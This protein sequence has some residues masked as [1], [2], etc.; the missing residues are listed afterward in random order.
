MKINVLKR[1]IPLVVIF[2]CAN[3]T[4]A[5]DKNA[6]NAY[7]VALTAQA[8]PESTGEG[9]VQL[10]LMDIKGE[11]MTTTP[12]AELN[13]SNPSKASSVT[14]FGLTVSAVSGIEID[15]LQLSEIGDQ[16]YVTSYAYYKAESEAA[17]G[18]YFAGWKINSSYVDKK[19]FEGKEGSFFKVLPGTGDNVLPLESMKDADAVQ[20]AKDAAKADT[21]YLYAVWKKY[22]LS[23]PIATNGQVEGQVGETEKIAVSFDLEGDVLAS[24]NRNLS[25]IDFDNI[26]IEESGNEGGTWELLEDGISI[27]EENYTPQKLT[28]TLLAGFTVNQNTTLGIHKATLTIQTAG[29][30][31]SELKIPIAVTVLDPNRPEA[32][33]YEEKDKSKNEIGDWNTLYSHIDNYTNPVLQLNTRHNSDLTLDKDFT[34]DLNGNNVGN[35][36]I[37]S[38]N[39]TIAYSKFGGTA[40]AVMVNGGKLI[41]N[42]G[43]FTS[44][45]IAQGATVEQNGATITSVDN[46]GALTT[47]EGQIQGGLTSSGTLTINGGSFAGDNAITITGG[48][49]LLKRGSINGTTCGVL[50]RG[51]TTTIEK[52]A[53]INGGDNYNSVKNEGGVVNVNCGKFGNPLVGNINF[54]SGYFKTDN[55][56]VSTIGMT[57]LKLTAGVE[58]NEGYQYFLGTQDAAKK[59]GVAVCRIGETG[60]ATLEDALAYANNNKDKEVIIFMTRDYTLPA[61]YYT[62][63]KEAT[64]VVP[65]DDNQEKLVNEVAPKIAFN[66]YQEE[67]DK[68]KNHY[69]QNT[70]WEFR[71]LTFAQGV[72]I[73]VFGAIEMTCKQ[74]SS[75]EA[76]TGQPVGPYGHL[77][78][79][80]GSHMT[81]QSGS[82]LRA[83]GFMTG[84]GE[85]DAR[86]GATVHEFFQMG[87]WKGALTSARIVGMADNKIESESW[88]KI[89]PVS[90]YFI[91]NIESPVTY[92]PGAVLTTA[93]AVSDG[94]YGALSVSMTANDIK[95]IGVSGRDNAI[96]LMDNTADAENTWVKKSY[97]AEQDIQNYDV[98]SCAHIGSMEINLGTI[99][100]PL[101][102]LGNVPILLNSAKFD[103]PITSNMKLHLRSGSMDFTQNTS[104][105]PGSEV[106]VDKESIV[107]IFMSEDDQAAKKDGKVYYS[108]ALYVYDADDWGE[109]AFT[110]ENG[111]KGTAFTKIVRYTPSWDYGVYKGRPNLRKENERPRSAT[112]NVHGT[113]DTDA[114]YVYTSEH[115]ANI[116]SSN[117]DAGTFIFHNS[118]ADAGNPE[119]YNIIGEDDFEPL[120]FSPAKLKNHDGSYTQ[121]YIDEKHFAKAGEAY[122]Y[123]DS[124]WSIW[125]VA[126]EDGNASCFMT[127]GTD[128]YAKPQEYVK[129]VATKN[130][131]G[132]LVGNTDHTYSDAAG[133]GR[134]F[135]IEGDDCQWWE[136]EVKDNLYHCIHPDN[137]TYYEWNDESGESGE[138]REKR[139]T[140]TWQ[141]WDGTIIKTNGGTGGEET[142]SYS[143]PYG[144]MAEFLGSNP[145]RLANIDYTYDFTG[146]T[147]ALGKVTSDV[148]YTA[149][150]E[151][152]SRKYTITFCNEGGSVIERQFLTHNDVPVCENTPTKVGHYL[153]WD[154]AIAAVTG[155]ATYTATWL[156][157][158][159]TKYEVRFVDYDGTEL[160][161][162]MMVTA[163][164]KPEYT[165]V[166]PT[167]KA[168]QAEK[169]G[170]KEFTY[171][172]DHWSPKITPVDAAITYTAVYKE[173]AKTYTVTFLNEDGSEIEHHNYAYGKVPVCSNIP[174]KANDAQYTYTLGWKPQIEAVR[175]D[176]TGVDAYKATWSKTTNKYTIT[177]TS[178]MP[179]AVVLTGAGIYD[180]NTQVTLQ[181]KAKE[182]EGFVFKGWKE[183]NNTKDISLTVKADATY[184]AIVERETPVEDHTV[185]ADETWDAA[186]QTVK[187]LILCSNGIQSGQIKNIT[188]LTLDGNAYFDLTLNA[189]ADRWY[190]IAVPWTVNVS[191]IRF[192]GKSRTADRDYYLTYYQGN[193]RAAQGKVDACWSYLT[194][195]NTMQPGKLYMLYLRSG[196]NAIRFPKK[197]GASLAGGSVST[198]TYAAQALEDANW[199]GIANPTAYYVNMSIDAPEDIEATEFKGQKLKDDGQ[200]YDAFSISGHTFVVGEP[201]FVQAV[202]TRERVPFSASTNPTAAPRR[203]SVSTT[204]QTTEYE[205]RIAAQSGTFTDRLY[206]SAVEEKEDSYII[207]KDLA[208]MGISAKVAQMWVN[209]YGTKLCANV[210][211]LA[212]S[213]AE[214]PLGIYAPKSGTYTIATPTALPDNEELYV[215]VNGKPVWCLAN[216]EYIATLNAGNTDNYGLLLV[217]KAPQIT[218]GSEQTEQNN[219]L[220]RK[221]LINGQVYIIRD[222]NVY[223]IFGQQ[224]Q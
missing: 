34:L 61:G 105:I 167:G 189:V 92:H 29:N 71:R 146:W 187:D 41:L 8:A 218:T 22:L 153:Q 94:L 55:Y 46:K 171:I 203:Y 129:V 39:V 108:G 110:N 83:W 212:D 19:S 63:P 64:I 216:G 188:S 114:G 52:L 35:I 26:T 145:T 16:A 106:E 62:V 199:N 196:A 3:S 182:K 224:I 65:M 205:V 91:Q 27:D 209:R 164:E 28:I 88:R 48:T 73:D 30:N 116:F 50:T 126:G 143:V 79:E 102:G 66:L 38:G 12:F 194:D 53:A 131:D 21:R 7:Y 138:W 217:R 75:D 206:I 147:P 57:E 20:K 160:Q 87:D 109:F 195:G 97:I 103:L 11:P 134:L 208:K 56:G 127:D 180:Y 45:A 157:E 124:K 14:M 31:P 169:D 221:V 49:A 166:T 4:W 215:T 142:D 214:F 82:Q 181:A 135:I 113:F 72:N 58:Y 128:Y 77:V 122:C 136:V 179:N 155:D 139:Y 69:H 70:P 137:D 86:R 118:A 202:S 177:L 80:E 207:G 125:K 156:E 198:Y 37:T 158:K 6:T 98:N 190:A 96:F 121:T 13:Q 115:G 59:N 112:I 159:P 23:N 17:N 150:Y 154:P 85:T 141:N 220:T 173:V 15:L 93:A 107:T 40:E 144:T 123:S 222:G 32:I 47:T 90:Q 68:E 67:A 193:V 184:T 95:I 54:V 200:G 100:I 101:G 211:E 5:Q 163:G 178:N 210:T 36:T 186:G 201:V 9:E 152:K 197:A 81:L 117:E 161:K 183:T 151:R 168:E 149:T 33:L 204:M 133:T 104:L 74:Y 25:D 132:N 89:F 51:G 10:T 223:S 130:A 2:L 44:L 119:V 78:M 84:K 43:E 76:Y 162:P 140:I 165:G 18:S 24:L 170:N 1:I 42:G 99:Y 176:R 192:D 219:T 175:E 111:T 185:A 172:F 120:T 191:D 60:Y 148:T 213:Q 174:T